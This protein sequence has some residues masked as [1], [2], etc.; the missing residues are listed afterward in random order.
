VVSY[1]K[2]RRDALEPGENYAY[3]EAPPDAKPDEHGGVS[4]TPD[5]A[6]RRVAGGASRHPDDGLVAA[7]AAAL[8]TGTTTDQLLDALQLEPT[9]ETRE[10][11]RVLL[12]G[13]TASTR[14][15]SFK[16]KARQI[17]ALIRGYPIGKGKRTNAATKEWHSAAWVV[18]E[19][20]GYGYADDEI[21][22]WLNEKDT[23]LPELKK[24]RRV[25]VDDVR[26][27]RSLDFK[28]YP[29][30]PPPSLKPY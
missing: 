22:R 4:F 30:F 24:R 17:A 12:E 7:I 5:Q 26:A 23:F 2:P 15:D 14:K 1:A 3:L 13:N 20:V 11:A 16:N 19:R 21:A 25:T 28:P 10:A 6:Y 27:L 18:Q 9:Q 29:G 8:L